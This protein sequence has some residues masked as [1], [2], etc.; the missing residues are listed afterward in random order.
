MS[1]I[2]SAVTEYKNN[3]LRVVNPDLLKYKFPEIF[4]G[5][6]GFLF[7]GGKIKPL[8]TIAFED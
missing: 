3:V 8:F 2:S 7:F 5:R 1:F 6:T 4:Q